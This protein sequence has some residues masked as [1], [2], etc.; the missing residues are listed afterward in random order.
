MINNPNVSKILALYEYLEKVPYDVTRTELYSASDIYEGYDPEKP[1]TFENCY[2]TRVY[3][4]FMSMGKLTTDLKESVARMLHDHKMYLSIVNYFREHN[5]MQFVGVMGGHALL[6]TDT[7]YREVVYLCKKMTE[8]GFNMLSG[9]GPGAMEATHLGALMA[10]RQEKDVE[11]VLKMLSVAPSFRDITWLSSAFEVL[12][13][14][15]QPKYESLGIPTWLYGHEPPTPFATHIAKFFLN[16]IRES[17]ILTIPFGGVIFTPGSAGTMQEIFQ[18]AVHNHYL[19]YGYSSPM[20]FLGTK[21]WTKDVPLYPLLEKLMD[22]GQYKNLNLA[23][24]DDYDEVMQI[25]LDFQE[26]LKA[27]TDKITISIP[28]KE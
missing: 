9:G 19:S 12:R 27:N 17:T 13:K 24:T 3:R 25:L 7:M 5:Y 20:I 6:R 14:Y 8:I 16:S 21:F 23:L 10:G 11:D 26:E 1:E 4:H 22:S 18:D 15:P 28:S 2:D